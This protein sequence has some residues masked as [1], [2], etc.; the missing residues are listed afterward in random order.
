[1]HRSAM[2]KTLLRRKPESCLPPCS[3]AHTRRPK[4]GY[5][6]MHLC[7][8]HRRKL[9][10]TW[11]NG[12]YKHLLHTNGNG[13]GKQGAGNSHT[14]FARRSWVRVGSSHTFLHIAPG[15]EYAHSPKAHTLLQTR[16]YSNES[17]QYPSEASKGRSG[18]IVSTHTSFTHGNGDGKQRAGKSNTY[19]HADLVFQYAQSPEAHGPK[20]HGPKAHTSLQPKLY[21]NGS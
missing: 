21:S 12:K 20:A 14:F 1:M 18:S 11:L 17:R 2:S 13:N 10:E 16:V 19:L 7:N 3:T 6:A 5:I 15:F 4:V 9:R 8:D